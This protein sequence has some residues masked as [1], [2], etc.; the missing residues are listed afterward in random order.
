[1]ATNRE[2][3]TDPAVPAHGKY[4]ARQRDT[5]EYAMYL[6]GEPV[7]FARTRPEAE[8][9]LDSLMYERLAHQARWTQ[10]PAKADALPLPDPD[11][12][13][14][15]LEEAAALFDPDEETVYS[16]AAAQIRAGVS[17]RT[18]STA[19]LVGDVLVRAAPQ[20][21]GWP[22]WCAC[23]PERCWHAALVE[24]VAV[25]HERQADAP[26]RWLVAA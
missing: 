1:M 17:L 24:A 5:G 10:A 18:D 12:I 22:W 11:T 21:I 2:S 23:G 7:G 9:T 25:A 26:A 14:E 4:I 15:V 16:L 19:T 20:R 8:T 6:D 3:T 13:T